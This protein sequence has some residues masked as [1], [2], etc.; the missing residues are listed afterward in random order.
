MK[1]EY[2][3]AL[4][5]MKIE[6]RLGDRRYMDGVSDEK[7]IGS[8]KQTREIGL[9]AILRSEVRRRLARGDGFD[10]P[11]DRL[12]Q[13]FIKCGWIEYTPNVSSVDIYLTFHGENPNRM[14]ERRIV[15][16]RTV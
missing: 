1:E 6:W 7:G 9:V 11:A 3:Q 8:F 14:E 10:T 4:A 5:P 16:P 15:P 13:K 2:D 12:I